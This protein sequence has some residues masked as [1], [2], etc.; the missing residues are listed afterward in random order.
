[1]LGPLMSDF[2]ISD[3][4]QIEFTAHWPTDEVMKDET[5]EE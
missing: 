2:T 4:L 5:H 3:D 1:M